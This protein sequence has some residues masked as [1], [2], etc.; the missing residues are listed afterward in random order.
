MPSFLPPVLDDDDSLLLLED[1][2]PVDDTTIEPWMYAWIVL[3]AVYLDEATHLYAM[4][5]ITIQPYGTSPA[6]FFDSRVVSIGGITRSVTQMPGIYSAGNTD[7]VLTNHDQALSHIRGNSGWKNRRVVLIYGQ[8]AYGLASFTSV[9]SGVIV[10]DVWANDVV[11]L[12][13]SSKALTRMQQPVSSWIP[14]VN[15]VTG[16]PLDVP[17]YVQS[18]LFQQGFG[19]IHS[20][21][22]LFSDD[23]AGQIPAIPIDKL[24]GTY[25]IGKG[26]CTV[27][28]L[29][30]YGKL[31]TDF[32]G[33]NYAYLTAPDGV[34][35]T[36]V[37]F[38][39]DQRD[40]T[41]PVDGKE[42]TWS[43]SFT[44][45]TR[46]AYLIEQTAVR[47]GFYDLNVPAMDAL[48]AEFDAR[49]FDG[50][51]W[52]ILK[53]ELKNQDIFEK[54]CESFQLWF[55]EKCDGT[56][57]FGFA[58]SSADPVAYFDARDILP[59]TFVQRNNI[60]ENMCSDLQ[61]NSDQG[62]V[63]GREF[64]AHQPVLPSSDEAI[65]LGESIRDNQNFPYV[66]SRFYD[67]V[68]GL[69]SAD[70]SVATQLALLNFQSRREKGKRVEF[71][72][73]AKNFRLFD[74]CD[75]VGITHWE[76]IGPTG[77]NGEPVR[78]LSTQLLCGP[79]ESI[80]H[81][82]GYTVPLLGVMDFSVAGQLNIGM[83]TLAVL[84]NPNHSV[85][86]ELSFGM[87]TL[88]VIHE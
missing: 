45:E 67:P 19:A 12:T 63:P 49:D 3:L 46:A 15:P 85:S 36:A 79:N 66:R 84:N 58:G 32:S 20:S 41:L 34:Q 69:D 64:Y 6:G 70:T 78:V 77:Y 73:P 13:L 82:S 29:Y 4:A 52:A 54:M 44:D 38:S 81:V 42:I 48:K 8:P 35:Y 5:G 75:K 27:D 76:G 2:V 33:I 60:L 71:T 10:E 40:A 16:Y 53:Q 88:A 7:I 80:I 74:L 17:S 86:G 37:L 43:G 65:N 39:T 25:M 57:A 87:G 83:A 18:T 61:Y 11:T 24:G 55:F 26:V 30:R 28:Y 9:Y 31:I 72:I 22:G 51:G 14:K 59:G 68:N 50:Q 23:N 47:A 56:Y 21:S 1:T 62:Y